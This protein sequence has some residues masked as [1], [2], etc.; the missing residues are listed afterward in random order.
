MRWWLVA[1][2]M[3]QKIKYITNLKKKNKN[4]LSFSTHQA[5]L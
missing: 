5:L 2:E 4:L 1:V 3:S